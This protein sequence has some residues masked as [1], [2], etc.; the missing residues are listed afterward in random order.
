MKSLRDKNTFK[1]LKI[2][3]E[4]KKIARKDLAK[5]IDIT[6][7]GI[8]KITRKLIGKGY[9]IETEKGDSIGGRPPVMLEINPAKGYIVGVFYAAREIFG[10]ITDLHSNIIHKESKRIKS[11][12][13]EGIMEESYTVI[14]KLLKKVDGAKVFGI[15]IAMNGLVDSDEG[16]SL[17]SPHYRWRNY[18]VKEILEKRYEIPVVIDNDVRMMAL[19]EM[20]YGAANEKSSFVVLYIG[21]GIGSGI[22]INGKIF[23]GGSFSAGEIGHL[24]VNEE[25][26]KFCSCGKKGCLEAEI[27]NDNILEKVRKE[28]SEEEVKTSLSEIK[29][30]ELKF[31]DICEAAKNGDYYSIQIIEFIGK[32]LAKALGAVVNIINPELL[33][34]SGEVTKSKEILYPVIKMGLQRYSLYNAAKKLEIKS[35]KLTENGATIGAVVAVY[36]K[37]FDG[38]IEI[39]E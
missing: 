18:N 25:G 9:L 16:I 5:I 1:V 31:E 6:P 21:E 8:T 10:I 22:V 36:K 4:Q 15:G 29:D 13:Q 33:V 39:G 11:K 27:S 14:D 23:Q 24:K 26:K 30:R 20:E 35:C 19:A 37:I 32:K 34:I 2:I 17:F 3:S 12:T 7:A 28:M 38:E